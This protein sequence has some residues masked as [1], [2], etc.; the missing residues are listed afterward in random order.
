MTAPRR[1]T[2]IALAVPVLAASGCG[3]DSRS[4][5]VFST[6][7]AP[8][9]TNTTPTTTRP[10]RPTTTATATATTTATTPRASGS[11]KSDPTAVSAPIVCLRQAGLANVVQRS[12]DTWRGMSASGQRVIVDGPYDKAKDA[13]SSADTLKDVQIVKASRRYVV[14]ASLRSQLVVAVERVATCLRNRGR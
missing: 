10:T 1:L 14:A 8:V 12:A 4:N 11:P 6:A 2:L 3:D 5:S 7:A 13:R 9:L